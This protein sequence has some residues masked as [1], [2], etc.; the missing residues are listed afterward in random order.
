MTN[1]ASMSSLT[2]HLL[3]SD[4]K[5]PLSYARGRP[6]LPKLS[7]KQTLPDFVTSRSALLL[8]RF[9][10]NYDVWLT[11][12]APW[13]EEPEYQHAKEIIRAI[14]PTNDP[15]ERLCAVSKRY[16]VITSLIFMR[17][18]FVIGFM[19]PREPN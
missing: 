10:P 13:D 11:K 4:I 7:S 17:S 14:V 2:F 5:N 8:E 18:N 12:R 16:K 15:A 6:E 19:L 1:T 9:T 3:L